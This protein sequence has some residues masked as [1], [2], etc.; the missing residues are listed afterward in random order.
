LSS[1]AAPS[2]LRFEPP[3]P[4]TWEL[5]P[6]HF[7][8]PVTRYWT[9]THPDAFR[10]GVADFMRFYGMLLEAMEMRYVNGFGYRVVVPV[11]DEEA[12]Q[13]FQRA[14][15]VFAGKLWREQLRDWDERVGRE[16]G[17]LAAQRLSPGRCSRLAAGRASP[18]Y[19]AGDVSGRGGVGTRRIRCNHAVPGGLTAGRRAVSGLDGAVLDGVGQ[20]SE[21]G[22]FR[23]DI[24]CDRASDVPS[25]ASC[26]LPGVG[27]QQPGREGLAR[28]P[29]SASVGAPR[30][31]VG[32]APRPASLYAP[33]AR[34]ARRR[35]GL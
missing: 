7:P 34:V 14:E 3:G 18:S 24:P 4:G 17:G 22:T 31:P 20:L 6:V 2:E 19:T 30:D 25:A 15:E 29:A 16:C 9:E 23:W 10:I 12:P 33:R 5:D 27:A 21:R 35:S 11:G 8:R 26:G 28:P 1:T 32:V 13:R